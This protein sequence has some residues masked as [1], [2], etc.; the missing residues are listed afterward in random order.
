MPTEEGWGVMREFTFGSY[1]LHAGGFDDGRDERLRHQLALLADVGA[2]AWALQECVGW[3]ASGCRALFLAEQ[4]LGLRGFLVP[5]LHHCDL[6]VFVRQSAGL[7]VTAER[8]EHGHP[9][10]H[11]VARIVVETAWP[12]RSL[13]LVSADLAPSSPS[14]R[15]A[16]AEALALIAQDGLVIAGGDWK[17]MPATDPEPQLDGTDSRQRLRELD[18]SAAY[19]LEE[20]GFIDVAALLVD[21]RPTVGHVSGPGY[22]RDRVY[23]TLP[24]QAIASYQV[25]TEYEPASPHRPVVATFD[26]DALK[27]E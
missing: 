23:T 1:N 20:A 19:A 13:H 6:A 22:R 2:D 11:A 5:S 14:I 21:L 15:R 27:G 7:R 25:V 24:A 18:R 9:Y 3:R 10:W 8:H 12:S 17:A 16:E 26:L 4:M